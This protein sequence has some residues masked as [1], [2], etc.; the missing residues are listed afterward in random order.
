MAKFRILG[1]SSANTAFII[2]ETGFPRTS[3]SKRM[4]AP[5][6]APGSIH[7][8]KSALLTLFSALFPPPKNRASVT[9]ELNDDNHLTFN[10]HSNP[11][12]KKL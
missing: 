1:Y 9:F 7:R 2:G 11:V 10:R 12:T 3:I 4:H 8:N 5:T 6:S